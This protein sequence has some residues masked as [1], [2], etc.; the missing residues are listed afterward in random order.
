MYKPKRL[1]IVVTDFRR[2][3]NPFEVRL[4]NVRVVEVFTLNGFDV[5]Q[6][7]NIN[8]RFS[9]TVLFV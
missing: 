1:A 3:E 8:A 2:L 7:A 4:E 6:G 9:Y 5:N